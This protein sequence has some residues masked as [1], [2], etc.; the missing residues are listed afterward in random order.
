MINWSVGAQSVL[1]DD[2]VEWEEQAEPFYYIKC[3]EFIMGTVRS[4]TK[5]ANSPLVVHP[6]AEY[7]RIRL[8]S[9]QPS[10][11]RGSKNEGE[12]FIIVK[13]LFDDKERLHKVLNLLKGEFELVKTFKGKDLVGR[14]FEDETYAGKR[15][16]FVIADE[17]IDPNKGTGAMTI[18]CNHSTDDYDLGKRLGLDDYFFDKIDFEGKMKAIAGECEGMDVK[19][20]RLK[21]AEIMK[22]K[23]LLVGEEKEYIHRVPLCYRSNCVVEPMVSPQW[24]ISVEKEFEMAKTQRVIFARHGESEDNAN[25]LI[26]NQD[27]P[28]TEKGEA[29]AEDIAEN[30]QGRKISK[31]ISSPTTRAL[32]TAKI[33]GKKLGLPVEILSELE[34]GD[35]GNLKGTPHSD[36]PKGMI[37]IQF[38]NSKGTGEK[39]EDY[40]ERVKTAYAKN[41]RNID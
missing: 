11:E 39:I 30:L 21:S 22:A 28:L 35:C 23:G 2:E 17:M 16:F 3:G 5:C 40:F 32:E 10:Q 18:S 6:E 15:K 26:Q 38:A 7:V 13:N 4:E 14:E 9:P 41:K 36:I 27:S 19:T 24:F 34:C 12:T 33:V 31:I 1:A 29:H 20:A 8:N 25:K 37:A